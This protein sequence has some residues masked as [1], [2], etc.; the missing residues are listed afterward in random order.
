MFKKRVVISLLFFNSFLTLFSQ[1]AANQTSEFAINTHDTIKTNIQ[2]NVERIAL[3][4]INGEDKF[5]KY[6]LYNDFTW[7][8]FL[9][10][11][12][13]IANEVLNDY[14]NTDKI[15]SYKELPLSLL[16]DTIPITLVDSVGGFC[17]PFIGK[18][19]SGYAFRGKREHHGV[20]L[21]LKIG[22]TIRSAFDGIVRVAKPSKSTGGYGNMVIIRHVNGLETYYGHLS[23]ILVEEEEYVKAGEIIGLGGSS[24]RSTGAH[25]HFETRYCGQS[26]DPQRIID[27]QNG[28]LITTNIVLKKHYFSIYSNHKQTDE[29]SL[30]ASKRILHTI[31]SGDT[32]SGLASKYGTTVDKLCKLN[33]ITKTTTLRIGNKLIVR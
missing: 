25:L 21:S 28:T 17:A 24:G 1:N 6:I 33:G 11:K 31:R 15:H 10:D 9:I 18:V 27:F 4:T 8:Y 32:L 5:T 3:D 23:K 12:P 20:D 14:W 29:Q 16:P 30:A 13:V 26:F 7:D 22:D 2:Q 19:G